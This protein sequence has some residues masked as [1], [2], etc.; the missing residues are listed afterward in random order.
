LTQK[1]RKEVYSSLKDL[2]TERITKAKSVKK[3]GNNNNGK[4][5]D[6]GKEANS[7][8]TQKTLFT[9]SF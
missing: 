5:K 7:S 4:G 1:E 9:F 3:N 2:V 6:K 8:H